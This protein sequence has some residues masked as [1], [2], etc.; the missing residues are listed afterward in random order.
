[1]RP[2]SLAP[3]LAAALSSFLSPARAAPLSDAPPFPPHHL[4]VAGAFSNNVVEFDENGAFVRELT[5][6]E[7]ISPRSLAFGPDGGLYV[8]SLDN[9]VL[10][11]DS[12]GAAVREFPIGVGQPNE[13]VFGPQGHLLVGTDSQVVQEYDVSGPTSKFVRHFDTDDAVRGLAIGPNGHLYAGGDVV[14]EYTTDGA[15]V[16]TI[17]NKIEFAT[18]V[19]VGPRG[20][21]WVR[22]S[23][24]RYCRFDALGKH[25]ADVDAEGELSFPEGSAFGPDGRLYLTSGGADDKVLIVDPETDVVVGERKA[26]PG[27]LDG[28]FALAFSPQRFVAKIA[29]RL[30][31]GS[32]PTTKVKEKAV[33]SIAPGT[34]MLALTDDTLD[35]FDLATTFD[36]EAIVLRTFEGRPFGAAE[37]V[38]HGA[39]RRFPSE[40]EGLATLAAELRGGLVG[41]RL[42]LDRAKGV[43]SRAGERGAFQGKLKAK[44]RLN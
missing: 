40:S 3:V 6:A 18:K 13:I 23:T 20:H 42:V 37:F 1:M 4:F 2:L 31:G 33:L 30:S 44:K 32:I 24:S 26:P 43:L 10:V 5:P 22:A 29:G 19:T 41:D 15:F 39:G 8:L 11:L 9:K 17:T 14:R 27:V 34:L 36:E 21:L 38:T 16:R 7:L 35:P 25:L 12:T 28:P